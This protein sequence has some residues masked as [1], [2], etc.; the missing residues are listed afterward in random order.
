M[1]YDPS[2]SCE[3]GRMEIIGSPLLALDPKTPNSALSFFDTYPRTRTMLTF[4]RENTRC[5]VNDHSKLRR[6]FLFFFNC[7]EKKVNGPSESRSTLK[8]AEPTKIDADTVSQGKRPGTLYTRERQK[9]W[10][11]TKDM[12]AKG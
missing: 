2:T 1:S 5:H 10:R 12:V 6:I 8:F 9:R 11:K 3:F 7:P 4:Q